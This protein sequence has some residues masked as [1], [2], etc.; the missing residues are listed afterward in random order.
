[1]A[2]VMREVLV[3]DV[4]GGEEGVVAVT[5]ALDGAEQSAELCAEHRRQLQE[6]VAGIL[7]EGAGSRPRRRPRRAA[8]GDARD[9]TR[10]TR[11]RAAAATAAK[12]ASRRSQM[13]RTTCPHC[14]LE[15]GVQNL[16]RHITAKHPETAETQTGETPPET[17]APSA[18]APE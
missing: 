12:G 6:A 17:G 10:T 13:P 14:G 8:V 5:V 9:G 11:K 16:S 15:M 1:M 18:P 7:G 2:R 4:C 3:C